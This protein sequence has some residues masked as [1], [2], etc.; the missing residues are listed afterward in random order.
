MEQFLKSQN[1]HKNLTCQLIKEEILIKAIIK[2]Y[3]ENSDKKSLYIKFQ[4][5]RNQIKE[6]NQNKQMF[7]LI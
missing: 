3:I 6:I 1:N 2:F 5:R 7:H 4:Q